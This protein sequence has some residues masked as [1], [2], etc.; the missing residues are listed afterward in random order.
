MCWTP[1]TFHCRIRSYYG[2]ELVGW[3]QTLP[4]TNL[5]KLPGGNKP[6]DEL[7]IRWRSGELRFEHCKDLGIAPPEPQRRT[8][9]DL[10]YRRPQ[11]TQNPLSSRRRKAG[12][13]D[14]KS[15]EIIEDSGSEIGDRPDTRSSDFAKDWEDDAEDESSVETIE[16]WSEPELVVDAIEDADDWVDP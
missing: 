1:H 12:K 16:D 9:C 13:S 11:S 14:P 2:V 5:S 7:L 4:F 15:V 6:L 10:G 3:P 8:R